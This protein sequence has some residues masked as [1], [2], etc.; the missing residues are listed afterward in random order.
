MGKHL[1]TAI[2]LAVAFFAMGAFAGLAFTVYGD[3]GI[4]STYA[5]TMATISEKHISRF[6]AAIGDN[7]Y[8][9]HG[10]NPTRMGVKSASDPKW[11]RIFE[12]VYTQKFYN[13]RWYVVAGNHDYNGNENAQIAYTKK[14]NRWYFP[15]FYYKFTKKLGSSEVDFF[16]LDTVPLYYPESELKHTF[17]VNGKDTKQ[18]AWFEQELKASKA[19]WKIVMAHHQ[20]FTSHGGNAYMAKHL[21]PLLEKYKV[22][23]YLNGHI[24]S[25]EHVTRNGVHY[26]TQGNAAFQKPVA[27]GH[28]SGRKLKFQYPLNAQFHGR[29]C[30]NGAC[31]G[32]AIFKILDNKKASI[33]YYNK[34]GKLLKTVDIKNRN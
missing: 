17:G 31:R 20:I 7:F 13:N 8:A 18:L 14:S 9:E 1:F 15:S 33:L 22:S 21:A 26:I 32:F 27:A 25:V 5:H 12:S 30:A 2:I 23:A 34:A 19:K 6:I 10:K 24:H 16:M 29:T 28:G 4:K 3:W 11:N